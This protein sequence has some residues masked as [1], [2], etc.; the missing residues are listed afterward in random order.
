[1]ETQ[2]LSQ[3]QL[4]ALSLTAPIL[5][6]WRTPQYTALTTGQ[7]AEVGDM[8]QSWWDVTSEQGLREMITWLEK[9][10]GHTVYFIRWIRKFETMT[11][12]QRRDLIAHLKE[13]DRDEYVRAKLVE[14]YRLDLGPYTILAF[15]IARITLLV[16]SG[17][18]MGWIPED[19]AW[20]ILLRQADKIVQQR[21]WMSHFDYLYSY[22]VG[23]T[24][25]MRKDVAGT[26]E[27]IENA[28]RLIT[29]YSSPW[30]SHAPWPT[31]DK[32]KSAEERSVH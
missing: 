27:S 29:N 16:R 32:T 21:M 31:F 14:H 5:V 15:D 30:L 10:G 26:L 20:E 18:D 13:T 4:F 22:I 3:Q 1:M 23:R 25:G 6:S 28:H 19:E 17:Y 11:F 24:F 8:L 9:E 7:S 2:I 12:M